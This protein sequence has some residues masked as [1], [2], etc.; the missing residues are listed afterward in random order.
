[1]DTSYAPNV[2][3]NN[4]MDFDLLDLGTYYVTV[5]NANGATQTCSFEIVE[6]FNSICF[7]YPYLDINNEPT[8]CEYCDGWILW[9]TFSSTPFVDYLWSDGSTSSGILNACAEVYTVTLTNSGGCSVVETIDLSCLPPPTCYTPATQCVQIL[10]NPKADFS[11]TPEPVPT[12]AIE[13]CQG[14]TVFFENSSTDATNYV[15]LFGDGKNSTE[16][17]PS[18]TYLLP[19]T[20]TASLIARND[21]FCADTSS[22]TIIVQPADIPMI[23]C[24]GSVCEG[25][26]VTYSTDVQC[27]SYLWGISGNGQ[28]IGGGGLDDTSITVEWLIGP[29]GFVS[30]Q[31]DGCGNLTA[32]NSPNVMP[33]AI[34]SENAQIVGPEKVCDGTVAEYSIPDFVGA[35]IIW[36]VS[37]A[38][39]LEDGQGTNRITVT[40]KAGLPN[41]QYVSVFF[42]NCFLGCEG[43]DTLLVN[44][45]PDFY[46]GGDIQFCQFDNGQFFSKNGINQSAVLCNWKLLDEDRNS[47]WSKNSVAT[48]NIPLDF[49]AGNY[50]VQATPK[51]VADYCNDFYEIPIRIFGIPPTV[52]GIAGDKLICPNNSYTYTAGSASAKRVLSGQYMKA[53]IVIR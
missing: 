31:T 39:T 1:M 27:S 19:G 48:I 42:E 53:I 45:K 33:I 26:T 25:E 15:W 17:A 20:F 24:L 2:P 16:E 10:Q 44:I 43:R 23:D 38:G 36:K 52:G 4:R 30:L 41:P 9:K 12:G 46:A 7:I 21:C 37:Q 18:H 32:C 14:Q 51:I 22:F 29:E 13:I 28:I 35:N 8:E 6:D 47:V 11:T 50:I 34:M 40:W 49:P 3:F 5:T